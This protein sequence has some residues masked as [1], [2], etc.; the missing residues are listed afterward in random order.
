MQNNQT[1]VSLK[2]HASVQEM[3]GNYPLVLHHA[4]PWRGEAYPTLTEAFLLIV[5]LAIDGSVTREHDHFP[6]SPAL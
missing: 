5:S 1:E 4:L 6:Q 2:V 3:T